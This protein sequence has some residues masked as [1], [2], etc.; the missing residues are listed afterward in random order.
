MHISE[1]NHGN[2]R[3]EKISRPIGFLP[4]LP[5]LYLLMATVQTSALLYFGYNYE[6]MTLKNQEI[7]NLGLLNHRNYDYYLDN[8]IV[9]LQASIARTIDADIQKYFSVAS[10]HVK[11]IMINQLSWQICANLLFTAQATLCKQ[12]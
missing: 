11:V 2:L 12:L 9:R 5:N 7:K 8:S 3:S 6:S 4:I 1:E 10:F